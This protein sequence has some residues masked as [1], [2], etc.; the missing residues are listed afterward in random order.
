MEVPTIVPPIVVDGSKYHCN[1]CYSDCSGL[2]VSCAECPDFDACLQCFAS[3]A[4]M[5]SHKRDHNYRLM[6]NGTFKLIVEEWTADE[7]MLLLDGIEQHGLGNW[8]DIADHVGTK[9]PQESQKH[10]EETYLMKNIGTATLPTVISSIPDHTLRDGRLSPTLTKPLEPLDIPVQEQQE[11]GY[12]V[13]RDDF[14]REYE[15]DAET[16]MKTL[17]CSRDDDEL[18]TALKLSMADMYWRALKERR[19]WKKIAR[20]YGLITSKHK[21]IASRRKI[22]KEDREFKDKIRPFAQFSTN[23]KWEELIS[24]RIREKELKQKIKE[25]VLYRRSGIKKV[26]ACQEYED[27]KLQ[28]EK[29]KENKKRMQVISPPRTTKT[30]NNKK[31]K[32]MEEDKINTLSEESIV[33]DINEFKEK[34]KVDPCYAHLSDKEKQLC[35]TM[36]LR[37]SRYITLKTYILNEYASKRMNIT[38][39]VK[40]PNFLTPSIKNSLQEFFLQCGWMSE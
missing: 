15:N 14:E 40:P 6:D 7:E 11:L 36:L 28:R 32:E 34:M 22:S 35:S 5:G 37:C 2:R 27:S 30:S 25:L 18:E 10:F 9:T 17:V 4:E 33:F 1:Y 38:F 12:M 29:K 16:L 20:H 21:L 24:N 19:R 26:A 13:N 3:G 31:E 39:K 8:D 23:H